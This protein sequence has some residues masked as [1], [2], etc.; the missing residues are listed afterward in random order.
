[1]SKR[2]QPQEDDTPK[3]RKIDH[4]GPPPKSER[5]IGD[6]WQNKNGQWRR[7]DGKQYQL[8]CEDCKKTRAS[9]GILKSDDTFELWW[10]ITCAKQNHSEEYVDCGR[11]CEDCQETKPHYGIYQEDG[12][13]SYKWCIE[14]ARKN[15]ADEYI[16]F[17]LKCEDCKEIQPCYGVLLSDGTQQKRWCLQCAITNHA[18]E[19]IDFTSKC[20]DCNSKRP[21]FG[22]IEADG[23]RRY[24]WC[25]DCAKINHADEYVALT[26]V[27]ITGC[28][29]HSHKDG[30]CTTC[31]PDYIPSMTGASKIACEFIDELARQLGVKDIQHKHYDTISSAITGDEKKIDKYRVDGYFIPAAEHKLPFDTSKPVIVEFHGNQFHGFPNNEYKDDFNHLGKRYGDLYEKTTQREKALSEMGYRIIRIFANEYIEWKKHSVGKSL[32]SACKII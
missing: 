1:M 4:K 2:K 10:C 20:I 11:K 23:T 7:W 22:I 5:K 24:K 9:Y 19:Y 29:K 3:K 30:Y 21:G 28:G 27:C 25:A 12:T 14:C 15:H 16:D 18:N 31:H 13:R 32:L 26:A 17:T 6:L 8:V